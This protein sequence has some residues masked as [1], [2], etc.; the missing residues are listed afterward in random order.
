MRESSCYRSPP[1]LCSMRTD[2]RG[3]GGICHG[4]VRHCVRPRH[5]RR[6][7][8]SPTML[9]ADQQHVFYRRKDGA[10]YQ[11]LRDQRSTRFYHDNWTARTVQPAAAGDPATMVTAEISNTC[12]IAQR[13][14]TS[15]TFLGRANQSPLRRRLDRAHRCP[16]GGR[17]PG[18]HGDHEPRPATYSTVPL[19]ARFSTSFGTRRPTGCTPITGPHRR[20]HP[21]RLAIPLPWSLSARSNSISSIEAQTTQ[22]NT[23]SGTR[24]PIASITTA[25]LR[26]PALRRPPV[27]PPPW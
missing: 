18:G 4:P 15:G 1:P 6:R 7:G 17:R 19:A 11:T 10:V 25:G 13:T 8:R 9:A 21:A 16:Q 27:I 2:L 20:A 26:S 14:A 24:P 12:S 23:S 22:F 5:T 3:R